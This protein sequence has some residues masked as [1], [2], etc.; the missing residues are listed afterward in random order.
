MRKRVK[1]ITLSSLILLLVNSLS[2]SE[3]IEERL[4]RLRAEISEQGYSY[5]VDETGVS[6][7]PIEKLCG[8]NPDF[9]TPVE[10]NPRGVVRSTL[11]P[12]F[13]WRSKGKMTPVKHQGDN[14]GSCWAFTTLGSYEAIIKIQ[15]NNEVDLSEQFLLVCNTN[16]YD[17][18]GGWEVFSM[19]AEGVPLEH[20]YPYTANDEQSCETHHS[21]YYPLDRYYWIPNYG[22]EEDYIERIMGP[23]LRASSY[24]SSDRATTPPE[25]I[26]SI[27]V[28]KRRRATVDIKPQFR[29]AATNLH[30]RRR[31]GQESV[32]L[33]P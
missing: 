26:N 11:P 31:S 21:K 28:S 23:E 25:S 13:S 5:T 27:T 15:T 6:H 30:R 29:A 9:E 33:D 2:F 17:C 16:N 8:L 20:N 32:N 24:E 7:I 18:S 22:E 10:V 14:C 1:L 12:T 4:S 3:D 19:L